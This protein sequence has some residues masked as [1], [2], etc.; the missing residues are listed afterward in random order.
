MA[1]FFMGNVATT[2]NRRHL[3]GIRDLDAGEITYLLDTAELSPRWEL[4]GGLRWDRFEVASEGW[5][6]D[7]AMR[8]ALERLDGYVFKTYRVYE[9]A[10]AAL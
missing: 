10:I 6:R 9:K 7:S 5:D 8:H 3:L 1:A 4:S 2:F